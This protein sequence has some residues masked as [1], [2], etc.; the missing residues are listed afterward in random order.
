MPGRHISRDVKIAA[1]RLYERD[2]LEITDILDCCGFSRRTWFRV[3]KIWR[4]TGD[5]VSPQMG[6]PG[7]KSL[8]IREDLDYLLTLIRDNPDYFLDEL[9]KL[10]ETN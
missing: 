8:L 10:M 9:L 5:V 2:L 6:Q 4:E 1:I 7:R 3:L